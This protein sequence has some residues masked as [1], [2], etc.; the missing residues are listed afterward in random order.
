MS[1]R[2]LKHCTVPV[3][4]MGGQEDIIIP[5]HAQTQLAGRIP[6]AWLVQFPR[7]GHGF[8]WQYMD[9][10]MAV[11]EA[12]LGEDGTAGTAGTAMR[13]AAV[14]AASSDREGAAA[15]GGSGAAE[16]LADASQEEL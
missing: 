7:A 1:W 10:A 15:A 6:G 16:G 11:M 12:F 2:A 8:L 4:L 9:Q 3:L 14:R 5:P 13:A